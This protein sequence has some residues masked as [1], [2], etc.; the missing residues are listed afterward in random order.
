[1][2][3]VV[4][5]LPCGAQHDDMALGRKIQNLPLAADRPR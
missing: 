1:M 2:A 5:P 4:L 3:R